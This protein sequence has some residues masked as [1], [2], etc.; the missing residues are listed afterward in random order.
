MQTSV[1]LAVKRLR[2]AAVAALCLGISGV[3]PR[4]GSAAFSRRP[5]ILQ[6]DRQPS[7]WLNGDVK[8]D[9]SVH[10]LAAGE[11]IPNEVIVQLKPGVAAADVARRFRLGIKRWTALPNTVVLA[12]GPGGDART[13]VRALASSPAVEIAAP[14]APVRMMAVP[15]DAFFNEQWGHR[16]TKLP[17]AWDVQRGTIDSFN[18]NGITVAVLDSGINF[19]HPDL[20]G[21]IASGG[22]DFWNND[23][24]P[25]DDNGHGS[26]VAG[27]VAA[28]TNNGRGVAGTTWEDVKVLPVKILDRNGDGTVDTVA[29]GLRFAADRGARIINLSVGTPQDNAVMRSAVQ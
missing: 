17:E 8:V 20:Q 5:S 16:L 7:W 22:H 10:A 15:N 4:E 19:S 14:N 23:S 9:P 28:T 25:T 6:R 11:T 29:A 21:R 12:A 3:G 26:H 27:I 13:L 1:N 18:P 2:L 24:D